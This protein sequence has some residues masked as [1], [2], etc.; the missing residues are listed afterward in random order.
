MSLTIVI[1]VLDDADALDL[2]LRDLGSSR[3]LQAGLSVR[4]VEEYP[5]KGCVGTEIVVVDG[6]SSDASVAVAERAGVR[7]L[8]HCRGRGHQ[9]DAGA[10]AAT[11]SWLWFLHADSGISREVLAEVGRLSDQ[12]PGWGRFDVR[13]PEPRLLRLVALAMNWRSAITGIC[14][15]DQGVFVHR[16]LLEAVGGVP[17]QPLME[18]IELSKRLKRLARPIRNRAVIRVSTRRWQAQGV[19]NTILLMWWLRI[20]YLFGAAPE[21]LA[22]R[23]HG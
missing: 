20:R 10:R 12:A 17:R 19:L 1:P 16:S 14:T 5:D 6:G 23:Y 8:R 18:D 15:G 7:V 9:L 4:Q 11:G 2:L 21:R 3:L 22:R 13:L